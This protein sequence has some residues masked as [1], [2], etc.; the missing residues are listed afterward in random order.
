MKNA[1]SK[2][3]GTALLALAISGSASA[4]PLSGNIIFNGAAMLNSANLTTAT[5][6]T[7]WVPAA[8]SVTGTIAGIGATATITAPWNFN[9]GAVASFWTSGAV[10]FDLTS[11]AVTFNN[12]AFLAVAGT[13]ILRAAGFDD[14]FG[15]FNFT[16]QEP[17]TGNSTFSFSASGEA[18]AR[19]PEGGSTAAFLG[20]GLIALGALA[21]RVK[22]S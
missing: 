20:L 18:N 15:T 8:V 13:G 11:S 2:F 19:V 3:L 12:G 21:R 4:G 17:N 16:T 22:L 1:L 7:S 6:V 9:S 5:A 10:T 14:T